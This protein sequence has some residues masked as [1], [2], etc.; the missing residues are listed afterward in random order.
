[1][2][3]NQILLCCSCYTSGWG[4]QDWLDAGVAVVTIGGGIA[5]ALVYYHDHRRKKAEWMHALYVKFFENKQFKKLRRIMDHEGI[6]PEWM[7]T[8]KNEERLVDYLNFFEQIASLHTMGQI[9]MEE[10]ERLFDYYLKLI[11]VQPLIRAYVKQWG[12]EDL[13]KLLK[14]REETAVKR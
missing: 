8:V 5:I 4:V 12:F 2:L 10:I 3:G 13:D 9:S 7:A 6:T 11:S 14:I 1:M